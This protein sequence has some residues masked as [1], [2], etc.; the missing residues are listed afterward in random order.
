MFMRSQGEG[1]ESW[2]QVNEDG[3]AHL[4]TRPGK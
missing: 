4:L 3:F 1:N 2:T